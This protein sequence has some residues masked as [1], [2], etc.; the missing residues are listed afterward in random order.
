MNEGDFRLLINKKMKVLIVG[1]GLMGGSYAKALKR[2][3]FTVN[4]ISRRQETINYAIDNGIIDAGSISPDPR[5]IASADLV[6]MGLY[7][8]VFV[9]WIK[10]NQQYFKPGVIITDVTG[11]KGSVVYEVQSILRSDAE[12]IAAHPMAGREVYGVENSDEK[13]F[14]GAN[15]I[16]VPTAKN[17]HGAIELCKD[18]GAMLGF[19]R[20]SVLSPEEHDDIIGFVSQLTHCIAVSLM[21]C[22]DNKRLVDY[23]GDSF[24]DLT[25]IARINDAMWSELFN[26]NKEPLLRQ[27]D[28]FM[29][30]FGAFRKM[31]AEGDT[32]G[33][34]Q[35]MRL[36][37]ER[38]AWFDKK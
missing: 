22:C 19:A 31:L 17:T 8:K 34:R 37:T 33:M 27:M 1:L 38:R 7:P 16:V 36:S 4:A 15:Y 25:R 29:E 26:M 11:V 10:D 18:L 6:I 21:T 12:F 28:A 30:E 23:T 35:K 20:I 2:L 3:G 14:F 13:M 9:Q 32:E 24:R 5:I